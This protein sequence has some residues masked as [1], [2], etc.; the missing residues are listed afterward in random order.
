MTWEI[1]IHDPL[2]RFIAQASSI[3][4]V[5]RLLGLVTRHIGQPMVIAEIT[6]GIILGPSLLGLLFP[7][8]SA[9]LFAPDSLGALQLVSQI[10]LILFMFLIGLELDPRLLRGRGRSSVA[11]SH[12]SIVVPFA[13]GVLLAFY[14]YPRWSSPDVSFTAFT[15]FLGAAMSITAFP[16]LARILSERR[17]L[18]TRVGAVTIACAAVDD[19]TAWCILAFVVAAAR[20]DGFAAAGV[21]TVLAFV[22]ILFMFFAVRPLLRRL[23]ARVT[24]SEGLTQNVVA[25]I[26]LLLFFSSWATELIGIHALFG[27]FLLGAVL[28]KDGVFAHALAEKLED[29][30]I[31]VLLPLFFAYS[32]VR[33]ELSLLDSSAA[34]LT[35]GLIIFVACLGKFGGSFA[36]ARLTGLSWRE[37]GALGILMNT[38]G[39]ME[40]IVLN[41][42]LDLGVISPSIFAMMVVMA[43]VTT[44]MTTPIL[45]LV[46]PQ[47]EL[48][49]DVLE[50]ATVAPTESTDSPE[51]ELHQF[52]RSLVCV[53][54]ERSGPGLLEMAEALGGPGGARVHALHLVTPSDRASFYVEDTSS[55]PAHHPALLPLLEH[56]GE[57]G[58]NV[59]PLSF[60]SSDPA[61]DISRIAGV[62]EIDLVLIGWHKP[63][64]RQSLLSG[65]VARV[66]K[67]SPAPVGIFVDR[68]LGDVHRGGVRRVLVPFVGTSHD[69][70]ALSLVRR[71]LHGRSDVEATLLH[72]RS[73]SKKSV[74]D[75]AAL[76]PEGQSF[77]EP[78]GGQVILKVV[79]SDE[80]VEV[81]LQES[82]NG[83]DLIVVGLGKE[84]GLEQR[85]LG[86]HSEQLLRESDVSLLIVRGAADNRKLANL[87]YWEK[88]PS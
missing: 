41:L 60:V 33:T 52:F 10:G 35:C 53:A 12:T 16:V 5:S 3:I 14:L 46:Y 86:M 32:G 31:V 71:L 88:E 38:R 13:M 80:P 81:T 63:L 45:Q 84:W 28:P 4:I 47:E 65:T 27:A 78:D 23:S 75:P 6:A 17:L 40:L 11:I 58:V 30:V 51:G 57:R 62:K 7:E 61:D 54:N 64:L 43:L 74:T 59:K 42:G 39:L 37:S 15:L 44:F 26:M 77:N 19:V 22:Y 68:G 67:E 66:L 34:W 50:D 48:E 79:E 69:Y 73:P 29:L 20:A 2:T 83:Y 8:M 76:S 82:K 25:L 55:Q 72:V 21:T 24:S 1:L 18:R 87:K 85:W 9:Q 49:K 36:A 70:A 56:A